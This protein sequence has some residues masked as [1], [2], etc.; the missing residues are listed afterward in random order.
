MIRMQI[1]P[2]YWSGSSVSFRRSAEVGL[3]RDK[4]TD[5]HR[6]PPGD[7]LD[8]MRQTIITVGG[9]EAGMVRRCSN[10]WSGKLRLRSS[11]SRHVEDKG[12]VCSP[13]AADQLG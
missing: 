6:E 5:A 7:C 2:C 11:W 10:R 9:M 13:G 8:V 1:I 4:V 3:S 12:L